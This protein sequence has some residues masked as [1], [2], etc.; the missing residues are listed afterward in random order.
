MKAIILNIGNELLFGRT[1][2]TNAA[3]ISLALNTIG[4]E[5]VEVRALSDDEASLHNALNHLPNQVDTVIITGG[6][7]PTPDDLTTEIVGSFIQEDLTLYPQAEEHIARFFKEA[8]SEVR[9]VNISQAYFPKSASL[10]ANPHGTAMGFEVSYEG[11]R[12]FCTPGV[13]HECL[14]MVSDEI[15]P[16]LSQNQDQ[17]LIQTE[18]YTYGLGETR[19]TQIFEGYH[20]PSEIQ[21]ASLP[22]RSGLLVR[23]SQFASSAEEQQV[24]AELEKHHLALQALIQ[25][26]YPEVV[27]GELPLLP[28]IEAMLVRE[29]LQVSV[30]ESCTSG[31]L[32]YHL[33]QTPGSSQWFVGGVQSYANSVKSQA[34]GVRSESLANYGA[35]SEEVAQEMALGVATLLDTDIALSIT[36]I[37][38]P[39]GGTPDK[40]V[41]TVCF[42]IYFQGELF[43]ETKRLRGMR[44]E[45]RERSVWHALDFLRRIY[46][47]HLN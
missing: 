18:F 17:K 25:E 40:P 32:G 6:L 7:G 44:T 36:G 26:K 35:V 39:D 37:A 23:L 10:L 1:I 8:W 14:H 43:S 31:L 34:L 15:I 5:T 27:M 22:S 29:G 21:F 13:P 24:Q 30:A 4:V 42:A 45:V 11:R 41:G 3:K 12:I 2:N 16:R 33:T 19:Q 20:L 46:Q 47:F 9:D 38:G 28:W